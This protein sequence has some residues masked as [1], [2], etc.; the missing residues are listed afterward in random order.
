MAVK[1]MAHQNGGEHTG[2]L[3]EAA[4]SDEVPGA[5]EGPGAVEVQRLI[6][7]T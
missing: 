7:R 3:R 1:I 5:V 6:N 4:M 2:S